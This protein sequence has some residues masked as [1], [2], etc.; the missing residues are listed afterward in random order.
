MSNFCQNSITVVGEEEIIARMFEHVRSEKA[1]LGKVPS[2]D[3]TKEE[4]R[5][6][7]GLEF[8]YNKVVPKEGGNQWQDEHW[9]TRGN[10]MNAATWF[11]DINE[12]DGVDLSVYKKP[13]CGNIIY[14]S[15]WSP[16]LPVTAA[17]SKQYPELIFT[18]S[19]F[20]EGGAEGSGYQ[21][22]KAGNLLEEFED[23]IEDYEQEGDYEE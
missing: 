8:D 23:D 19:Y 20:I 4:N 21:V 15:A 7:L 16:A 9:G 11:A 14:S 18:H 3:K 1:D 10:P 22:W 5:I 12:V 13:A 17:L 6:W 2:P